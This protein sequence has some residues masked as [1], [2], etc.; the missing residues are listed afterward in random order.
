MKRS[1][2]RKDHDLS[3]FAVMRFQ[4]LRKSHRVQIPHGKHV[5]KSRV[6][7]IPSGK[8]I[9]DW[10]DHLFQG[11]VRPERSTSSYLMEV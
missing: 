10:S 9:L 7:Q 2:T 11:N 4:V 1:I 3:T 8:H 5:C 6:A